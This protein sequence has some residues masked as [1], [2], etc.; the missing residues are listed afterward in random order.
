MM[1]FLESMSSCCDFQWRRHIHFHTVA[2]PPTFTHFSFIHY[3]HRR[4]NIQIS[5]IVYNNCFRLDVDYI[6]L[7]K[8]FLETTFLPF[9]QCR[10]SIRLDYEALEVMPPRSVSASCKYHPRL[11]A[12]PVPN[13]RPPVVEGLWQAGGV[14][15]HDLSLWI[16]VSE[17]C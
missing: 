11:N 15:K 13:D 16:L 10:N 2:R 14:K 9:Q 6:S 5:R 1:A 7:L 17:L 3:T 4:I 8:L 12:K